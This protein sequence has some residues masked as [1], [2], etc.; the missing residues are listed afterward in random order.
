MDSSVQ[1]VLITSNTKKLPKE[2]LMLNLRLSINKELYKSN[3]IS[4]EVF[5]KMQELI[6]KKMNA[7]AFKVLSKEG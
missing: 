1:E 6:I 2:Y 3:I 5:R 4:F 7:I